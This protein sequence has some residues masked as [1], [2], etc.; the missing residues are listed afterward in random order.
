[1][2]NKST[3]FLPISIV[4]AGLLIGIFSAGAIIYSSNNNS[5]VNHPEQAGTSPKI[6]EIS[7]RAVSDED[8]IRGSLD[9]PVTLIDYSDLECP[10]CKRHH[11]TLLALRENF[12]ENDFAWIYRHFPIAQLHAKAIP[13][14]VASECVALQAGQ[15]GFWNFTDIVYE[16]T[17][18][19]DGLDLELIGTYAQE[20]GV[21]DLEAFQ[22]CYDNQET[23]SLVEADLTDAESALATGTPY[24][25]IVSDREINRRTRN[26]IFSELQ[27]V[28]ATEYATFA[29]NEFAVGISGALPL[30]TF[31]AIIDI[32][33]EYNS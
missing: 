17:P 24:S 18:S 25:L 11:S 13:E 8:Y 1:M 33:I 6:A 14:S 20:A 15:E 21:T 16:I 29:E 22:T 2:K 7:Y 30:E 19:N 12:K 23:L 27:K 26:A 31:Q 3:L 5:G 4:V 10:F 32:L 28:T 9:A